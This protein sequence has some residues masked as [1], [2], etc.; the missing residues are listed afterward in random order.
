M[1][2]SIKLIFIPNLSIVLRNYEA[3]DIQIKVQS[4]K[5]SDSNGIRIRVTNVSSTKVT[6]WLLNIHAHNNW[7]WITTE[8]I[9][10][11][12]FRRKCHRDVNA[13]V[14]AV[15]FFCSVQIFFFFI[16]FLHR[17]STHSFSLD[18]VSKVNICAQLFDP[19]LE[20]DTNR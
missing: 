13:A 15:T 5:N 7:Q 8:H 3:S 17:G 20:K 10:Y 1:P 18:S 2:F 6:S 4:G 9:D 12:F 11:R 16:S 14:E 19:S